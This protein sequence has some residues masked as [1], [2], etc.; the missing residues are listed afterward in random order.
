MS[1]GD[2]LRLLND[3]LKVFAWQGKHFQKRKALTARTYDSLFRLAH[4]PNR[5]V[6]L[7]PGVQLPCVVV[8]H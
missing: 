3:V 5:T 8:R 1:D 7:N 4:Y 6:V 2:K